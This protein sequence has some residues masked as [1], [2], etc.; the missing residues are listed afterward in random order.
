MTEPTRDA[1]W[2]EQMAARAGQDALKK[3]RHEEEQQARYDLA[4]AQTKKMVR[5][6]MRKAD[7]I[8][9]EAQARASEARNLKERQLIEQWNERCAQAQQNDYGELAKTLAQ[10]LLNGEQGHD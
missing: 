8:F 10:I 5:A 4:D 1:A 7:S 2:K 6:A 9:A 3:R